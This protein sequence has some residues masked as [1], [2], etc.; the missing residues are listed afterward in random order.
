ML[1]VPTET[2]DLS[3]LEAA[4]L[5]FLRLD[6]SRRDAEKL[7]PIVIAGAILARLDGADEAF[8]YEVRRAPPPRKAKESRQDLEISLPL[9]RQH[10]TDVRNVLWSEWRLWNERYWIR[11]GSHPRGDTETLD[12]VVRLMTPDDISS[13]RQEL[14]KKSS[15]LE[16]L[17]KIK[18]HLRTTLP[19]IVQILPNEQSRIVALPSLG[20]SRDLW[21]SRVGGKDGQD[22]QYYDIRY[23]HVD[24]SLTSPMENESIV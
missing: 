23:K 8:V 24:D 2:M 21:S 16:I 22:A 18:G 14:G 10:E 11:I 12:I 1:V 9:Q 4:S 19:V 13:L 20:W 3:T 15:L 6:E 17:R 5:D 7:A